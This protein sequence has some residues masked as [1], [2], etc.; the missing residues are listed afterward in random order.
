MS[1][2]RMFS[3]CVLL[4]L[5]VFS[6]AWSRSSAAP[7]DLNAQALT[8]GANENVSQTDEMSEVPQVVA[9]GNSLRAI[10]GERNFEAVVVSE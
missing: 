5:S 3:T 6:L 2:T 7:S 10:W 9:F 8:L 1:K 4:A